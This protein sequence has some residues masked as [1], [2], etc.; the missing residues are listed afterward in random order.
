VDAGEVVRAD[1][2]GVAPV[3]EAGEE[4]DT[5]SHAG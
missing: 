5:V 3:E 1:A 4:R 2:D